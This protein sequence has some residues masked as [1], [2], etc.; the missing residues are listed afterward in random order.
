MPSYNLIKLLLSFATVFQQLKGE[1]SIL[2]GKTKYTY[3]FSLPP[4]VYVFKEA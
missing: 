2:D 4:I 3:S 1:M